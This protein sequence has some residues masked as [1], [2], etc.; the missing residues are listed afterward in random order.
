[1]EPLGHLW[2]DLY[3]L[4]KEN[5]SVNDLNLLVELVE[6]C[7]IL[8]GQCHSMGPYLRRK[9]VLIVLFKDRHKV[10]SDLKE[11]TYCFEKRGKVHSWGKVSKE[12]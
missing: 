5:E 11:G 2:A 3:Q 9:G 10:K 1:M 12:S 4:Q 6:Q 8:V 7:V